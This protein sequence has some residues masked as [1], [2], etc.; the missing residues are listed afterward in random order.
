MTISVES[1]PPTG[2]SSP[3]ADACSLAN[4]LIISLTWS[5]LSG[6]QFFK[7]ALRFFKSSIG[8]STR[9][10]LT[11]LIFSSPCCTI[12]P[13]RSIVSP[14]PKDHTISE[15]FVSLKYS[16][17]SSSPETLLQSFPIL[18]TRERKSLSCLFPS[19]S[20]IFISINSAISLSVTD[21]V[22]RYEL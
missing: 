6:G 8:V 5:S 1:S 12:A 2:V 20:L 14:S 3:P 22:S 9:K 19:Y 15:F 13:T 16:I 17:I 18:N 10:S 11:A 4:L 7:T 21:S